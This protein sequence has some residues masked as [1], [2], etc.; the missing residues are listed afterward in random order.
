MSPSTSCSS[1]RRSASYRVPEEGCSRP[2]TQLASDATCTSGELRT[3]VKLVPSSSSESEWLS[4]M[5]RA[6]PT[7]RGSPLR[8]SSSSSSSASE[9]TPPSS[10]TRPFRRP[11]VWS[12]L[13]S[14]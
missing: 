10:R 6:L 12:T 14:I 7:R 1:E 9:H 11:G 13:S 8:A 3:S 5:K 4:F 2:S